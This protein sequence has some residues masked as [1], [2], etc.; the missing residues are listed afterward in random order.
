MKTR[1]I[2]AVFSLLLLTY[3]GALWAGEKFTLTTLDGVTI[4]SAGLLGKPLVLNV[5]ADW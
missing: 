3:T 5:S 1:L 4:D 2:A